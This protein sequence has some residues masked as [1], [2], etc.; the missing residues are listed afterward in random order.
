[1]VRSKDDS[2]K[3]VVNHV[4]NLKQYREFEQMV[5]KG[6]VSG[7]IRAFIADRVRESRKKD[8]GQQQESNNLNKPIEDRENY[9]YELFE[10]DIQRRFDEFLTACNNL[11]YLV[12]A[13]KLQQSIRE[14]YI[15]KVRLI[16][17][18]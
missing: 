6:N 3:I 5:G 15:E 16:R 1:M 9:L 2:N 7:E 10:K 14:R 18:G 17:R 12:K 4:F 8:E 11:D 13:V